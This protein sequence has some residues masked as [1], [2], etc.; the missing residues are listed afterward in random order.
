MC[1]A[2]RLVGDETMGRPQATKARLGCARIALLIQA[3]VRNA[4]ETLEAHHGSMNGWDSAKPD[5]ASQP[6]QEKPKDGP[7]NEK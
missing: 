2:G 6:E 3:K 5:A 4:F 7:H 1:C